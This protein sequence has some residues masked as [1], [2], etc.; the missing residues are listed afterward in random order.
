MWRIIA[1]N[2][3]L[4]ALKRH[5]THLFSIANVRKSGNIIVMTTDADFTIAQNQWLAH[6]E[7]QG[8]SSHTRAAYRRALTHFVYWYEA[9][10]DQPPVLSDLIPRDIADWQAHQQTVEKAKPASI[11]QRLTAL[12]RFLGWASGQGLIT[13]NPAVGISGIRPEARQPKSLTDLDLRRFLRAVDAGGNARDIAMVALLV[14]ASLRVGELLA[15]KVGDVTLGERSGKV[16]I[17]RGKHRGYRTVPLTTSVRKA[18]TAWLEAHPQADDPDAPLWLGQ[19]GPLTDRSAINRM[20][21]K[22]ARRAGVKP[23]GPHVLRHTFATRYLAANPGD[24]RGLAALLGHSSLNTVMIYTEPRLEDLSGR[25][26][27]VG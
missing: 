16:V 17:R 5:E 23:F 24:L 9:T 11:N 1:E 12:S 18:L 8:K 10:Y 20:L 26:E 4:G 15:L 25:M 22:Y 13:G 21:A 3:I 27:R 19:R 14:G 2:A 7:A 6:L